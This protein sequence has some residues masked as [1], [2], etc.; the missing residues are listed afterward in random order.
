M[1]AQH[2]GSHA[3]AANAQLTAIAAQAAA[4]QSAARNLFI[5]LDEVRALLAALN[6]AAQGADRTTRDP[7]YWPALMQ[8]LM[9]LMPSDSTLERAIEDMEGAL[10][11]LTEAADLQAAQAAPAARARGT[12]RAAV[13]CGAR[14]A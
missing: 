12:R 13:A 3:I 7:L 1:N 10:L 9:R 4:V 8:G 2:T 5:E 11:R 14:Q 6:K